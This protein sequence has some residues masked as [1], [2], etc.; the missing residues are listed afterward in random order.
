MP[1]GFGI[2]VLPKDFYLYQVDSWNIHPSIVQDHPLRIGGERL[3]V[4]SIFVA[5]RQGGVSYLTK[6]GTD[7]G[8]LI[9][10][11]RVQE[12]SLCGSI[13]FKI[14]TTID[15]KM[16]TW[17]HLQLLRLS[18]FVECSQLEV[19]RSN[20]IVRCDRHQQWSRCDERNIMSG[21]MS[22]EI[23]DTKSKC[24]SHIEKYVF[25]VT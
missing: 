2:V 5:S 19:C 1:G 7:L 18:G 21:I 6:I 16:I 11:S 24:N 22:R 12:F 14:W 4:R 15:R 25:K 13:P 23:L 17:E 20:S 3:E 9:E 10:G 8:V